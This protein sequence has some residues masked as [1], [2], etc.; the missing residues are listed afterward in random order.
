LKKLV[1]R[2]DEREHP[3]GN[4]LRPN[5][6]KETDDPIPGGLLGVILL[7]VLIAAFVRLDVL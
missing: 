2:R 1:K 7:I 4:C 3:V 6:R 5:S